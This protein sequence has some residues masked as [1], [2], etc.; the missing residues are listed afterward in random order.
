MTMKNKII[1]VFLAAMCLITVLIPNEA[2]AEESGMLGILNEL[3]IMQGDVT[4]ISAWTI[5]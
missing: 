4:G 5:P 1:A 3:E 2:F